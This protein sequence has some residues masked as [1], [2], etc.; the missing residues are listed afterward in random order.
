[1]NPATEKTDIHP[2]V[3]RSINMAIPIGKTHRIKKDKINKRL[4]PIEVSVIRYKGREVDYVSLHT[5]FFRL[6]LPPL[7]FVQWF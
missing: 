1:M 4:T 2:D 3:Y 6:H 5:S 7:S